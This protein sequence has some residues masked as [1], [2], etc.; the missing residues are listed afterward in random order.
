MSLLNWLYGDEENAR[1]AAAADAE[2][3]R[4][5]DERAARLGNEWR[6]QV[7]ANYDSQVSFDPGEQ[8]RQVDDAF[9][10][11]WDDGKRNV[12]GFVSGIFRTIGDALSAVL[13][14]VPL[15]AWLIGLAALWLYLGAPGLRQLK[16]KFQ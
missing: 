14:G 2:L 4:L 1:R 7:H 8:E 3:R 6:D 9:A 16:G 5:N 15:W 12:S 13:L 11:G 10:E